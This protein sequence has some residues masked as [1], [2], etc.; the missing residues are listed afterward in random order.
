MKIKTITATLPSGD[1]FLRRA[2]R[3]ALYYGFI[4]AEKVL[5]RTKKRGVDARNLESILRAALGTS[6]SPA[7]ATLLDRSELTPTMFYHVH[8]SGGTFSFG[9]EVV[10]IS[11][12]L[13]EALLI[14]TALAILGEAG[15]SEL[16]VRVN[17]VGD[18]DSINRFS[19]EFQIYLRKHIEEIPPRGQELMKKDSLAIFGFLYKRCR[20]LYEGAPKPMEFLSEAS[21]RHLRE[22]LEYLETT[23]SPY[24]VD[25]DLV[26]SNSFYSQTFFEIRRRENFEAGV[27][28]RLIFAHGGRYDDVLRRI[29]RGTISG[30]RIL[31]F[32]ES[33]HTRDLSSPKTSPKPK[34]Y[35]IQ[36][37]LD[38]RL[39]SL[40]ILDVLRKAHVPLTQSLGTET[41]SGQL[42]V[43]ERLA[44]PYAMIMGQKEA[45][46]NTVIVRNLSS[47]RQDTIPI[48]ILPSYIK[49]IGL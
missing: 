13:A 33:D 41:L 38:A 2:M 34:V 48:A 22:M 10:G 36:L 17:S 12:S 8:S 9:L 29:G 31:I 11:Q 5:D 28:S 46:E 43:A 1:Q 15:I 24:E 35:F 27:P 18:R 23:G 3:I 16:C 45:L 4:P 32:A 26:P 25:N 21:R 49:Q 39:R 7:L 47:R 42:S 44:I 30:A 20:E 40:T 37:G 6:A 14:K 19:R